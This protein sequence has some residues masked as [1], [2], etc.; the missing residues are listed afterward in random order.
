MSEGPIRLDE[1]E[2]AVKE[3]LAR[4][5]AK[6]AAA[7]I[8][9]SQNLNYN[10]RLWTIAVA[11]LASAV[12]FLIM[13]GALSI[14]ATSRAYDRILSRVL[15][16]RRATAASDPTAVLNSDELASMVPAGEDDD[17]RKGS[18]PAPKDPPRPKEPKPRDPPP[19]PDPEAPKRPDPTVVKP[20]AAKAD[21]IA[22]DPF[23]WIEPPRPGYYGPSL[24]ER[25]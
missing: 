5:A 10:G 8:R 13:G 20:T 9:E 16:D 22:D 21:R 11:W 14:F 15:D 1:S 23:L 7:K 17:A 4:R 2:E 24:Y 18:R 25:K 19:T 6:R 3:Q 12:C